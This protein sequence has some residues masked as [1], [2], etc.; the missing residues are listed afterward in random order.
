MAFLRHIILNFKGNPTIGCSCSGRSTQNV[1][2]ITVDF[3]DIVVTLNGNRLSCSNL[4]CI[5]QHQ[6]RLLNT[7]RCGK[8]DCALGGVIGCGIDRNAGEHG[9]QRYQDRESRHQRYDALTK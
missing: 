9:D 3:V 7:F 6:A 8:G 4:P 1:E 5:L 2:C